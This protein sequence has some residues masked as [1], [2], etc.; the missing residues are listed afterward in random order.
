[1]SR[2]FGA[3]LFI[4]YIIVARTVVGLLDRRYAG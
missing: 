2:V 4:V 1:M 3:G